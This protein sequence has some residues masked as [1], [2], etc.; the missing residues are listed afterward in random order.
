MRTLPVTRRR[1]PVLLARAI[2]TPIALGVSGASAQDLIPSPPPQR[3]AIVIER[4]TIHTMAGEVIENGSIA[5]EGGVISA[6]APEGMALAFTHPPEVIDGTG[7]HVYPGLIA[8]YTQ[9]GLTEIG[10][11]RATNDSEEVGAL[12]PEVAA[13][14]AV[15]PDST[16]LPVTRANGIL[17]AGVMPAGSASIFG[18]AGP[19]G[20]IPGHASVIRMS[21]WTTADLTVVERAGLV[22][23][24][25][26]TRAVQEWWMDAPPEDQTEDIE[27]AIAAL[28]EFVH[29]ARAYAA[30]RDGGA[31]DLRYEGVLPCLPGAEPQRP[32]YILA[33]DY[34]QIGSALTFAGRH[35][36]KP[37]IVGG[38]DAHLCTEQLLAHGA[39]VILV[40]SYRIPK[41]DDSPYDQNY[42]S[43]IALEEAGVRWALA[44][45]DDTAH[46][47]N[48]PYAAAIAVA[49][50]LDPDAALRAVTS[51][52]AELLGVG[53]QLG[54]LAAGRAATLLITDGHPLEVTTTIHHAFIDGR[55][56]DL[57]SKHTQ[58]RDKYEEKYRQLGDLPPE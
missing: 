51:S 25:P 56:V 58:L 52:A 24:F 4:V 7:L 22:I 38:R 44:S 40:T 33:N 31:I 23:N 17:T 28:D 6:I 19:R 47:R 15:N 5:F 27:R 43:C 1:N 49:H 13:A 18:D 35:G 57:R 39:G 53:E 10:A 11:V 41:R 9:L 20:L 45:G 32:V 30:Q 8:P 54:T 14:T 37:V 42:T 50:G 12:T 26:L 3:E 34:D 48:L 16:L 29:Q 55:R 46:E 36:L 21:G 2:A